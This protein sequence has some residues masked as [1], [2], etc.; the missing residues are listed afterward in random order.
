[1]FSILPV[2]N[3]SIVI[4]KVDNNKISNNITQLDIIEYTLFVYH[5]RVVSYPLLALALEQIPYFNT[6]LDL[7]SKAHCH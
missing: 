4:L 5:V 2:L 6:Y 3:I 1:M 7:G